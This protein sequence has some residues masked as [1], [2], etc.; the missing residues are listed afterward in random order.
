MIDYMNT[1]YCIHAWNVQG[2]NLKGDELMELKFK[3]WYYLDDLFSYS[4]ILMQK[5]QVL[6]HIWKSSVKRKWKPD[7]FSTDYQQPVFRAHLISIYKQELV[8]N[9]W[10]KYIQEEDLVA[11]DDPL[12]LCLLM[13]PPRPFVLNKLILKVVF[14]GHVRYKLLFLDRKQ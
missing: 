14:A 11:P 13:K 10:E 4:E 9:Q 7:P 12:L 3:K 8:N 6:S 2:R 5:K 1:F